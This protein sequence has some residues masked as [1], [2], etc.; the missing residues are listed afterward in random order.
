MSVNLFDA[1]YYQAANPDLAAAGLSTKEQL[2]SHFLNAGI[3]EGRAFS[4]IIDLKFY[5]E[6]NPDLAA[7]GLTTNQQ[8][9]EHLQSAGITEGRHFSRLV[10]LDFYLAVNPD[11]NQAFLG[12]RTQAFQHLQTSGISENRRFSPLVNLNFYLA[13][14]PD[15][16]Q[17]IGS[18]RYQVFTHLQTRGIAEE[19]KYS[20]VF[21]HTYYRQINPD[22]GAANL[23]PQ[24]LLTHFQTYGL[25]EGRRAATNLDI[26]YYL[27]TNTDLKA[28][29]FNY[30]QAFQH[31][32]ISGWREGRSSI[33]G[34]TLNEP[35]LVWKQKLSPF[36]P[37]TVT[38]G[39]SVSGI[40]WSNS[41]NVNVVRRTSGRLGFIGT[42]IDKFNSLT[43]ASFG[44]QSFSQTG[45]YLSAFDSADNFYV[46]HGEPENFIYRRIGSHIV[47]AKYDSSGNFL[48]Q[49]AILATNLPSHTPGTAVNYIPSSILTVDNAGNVFVAADTTE[50]LGGSYAGGTD[51]F[52]IKYDTNGNQQ[53][54]KQLGTPEDEF[55]QQ[56]AVDN[57]GNLYIAGTTKGNLG[58]TYA[59]NTDAWIAKYDSLTGEKIWIRQIGTANQESVKSI[60]TDSAGNVFLAGT[61]NEIFTKL[62]GFWLATYDALT[63]TERSLAQIP[64]SSNESSF[65]SFKLDNTGNFYTI[66]STI[67]FRPMLSKYNISGIKEWSMPHSDTLSINYATPDNS[68]NIYALESVKNNE[69]REFSVGKLSQISDFL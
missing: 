5:Q 15:V 62:E 42:Y 38:T 13:A 48:W 6:N 2:F 33:E 68:G 4:P 36:P 16:A 61:T 23:N 52:I 8:I 27:E 37:A 59:G 26:R 30:Q 28:A 9:Y 24:Q 44:I 60:N 41:G 45:N 3:H 65:Q 12:D 39:E 20:P 11:V 43:G 18:D 32:L 10:D 57:V 53:W 54:V 7:A 22:L 51:A 40:F 17:A 49:Q 56:I 1:N 21:D 55:P 66:N 46:S 47:T 69:N 64:V 58:G 19:R 50:N 25:N 31:A 63:G 67:D 29:G 34:H 35:V 14:N